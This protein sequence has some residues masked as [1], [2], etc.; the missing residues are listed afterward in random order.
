MFRRYASPDPRNSARFRSK[1]IVAVLANVHVCGDFFSWQDFDGATVYATEGL[2]YARVSLG[3]LIP[4]FE[5]W[6]NNLTF[7]GKVR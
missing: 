6:G 3:S 5:A 4:Y 1:F 7:A 2:D